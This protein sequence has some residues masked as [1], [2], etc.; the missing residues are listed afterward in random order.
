MGRRL[1]RVK[2]TEQVMLRIG[3][4]ASSTTY[5]LRSYPTPGAPRLRRLAI[6][7]PSPRPAFAQ[8]SGPYG[9]IADL[10]LA[11]PRRPDQPSVPAPPRGP[12]DGKSLDGWSSATARRPRVKLDGGIMQAGGNDIITKEKFPAPSAPAEFRV[13]YMPKASGQGRQQRRLRP[14]PLGADPRYYGP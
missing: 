3:E 11:K 13:L 1:L 5:G 2:E 12:L 14:W 9:S 7:T 10:K 6:L 8:D 4:P